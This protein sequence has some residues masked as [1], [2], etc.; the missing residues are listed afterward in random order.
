M[1]PPP[2]GGMPNS[3]LS[4]AASPTPA[5]APA[6]PTVPPTQSE[7]GNLFPLS[8]PTDLL[9]SFDKR[10]ADAAAE[11][12]PELMRVWKSVPPQWQKSLKSALD[13]RHKIA[14]AEAD[15]RRAV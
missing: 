9:S 1:E 3:T 13:R 6:S 4:P 11:G 15:E 5:E 7:A 14:A 2:K 12:T 10:L 8:D